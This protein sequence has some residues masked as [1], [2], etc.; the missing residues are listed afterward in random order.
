MTVALWLPPEEDYAAAVAA[1]LTDWPDWS[2]WREAVERGA[3][4]ARQ[5]GAAAAIV[6]APVAQVIALAEAHGLDL[7]RPEE[8]ARIPAL[9]LGR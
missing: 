5:A 1:G 8:R 4:E 9:L 3:E 6:R 2:T 7:R